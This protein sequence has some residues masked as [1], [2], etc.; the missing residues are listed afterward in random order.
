MAESETGDPGAGRIYFVQNCAA[1][2]T[3]DLDGIGKRYNV[4]ALRGQLL[5]PRQLGAIRSFTLDA[6]TDSKTASAG[7]V[8]ISCEYFQAGDVLNLMAYLRSKD[9]RAASARARRKR[10]TFMIPSRR[11]LL[12][13]LAA[14]AVVRPQRPAAVRR[15]RRSVR[16]RD[17]QLPRSAAGR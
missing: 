13:A 14:V 4:A 12:K 10:K 2:H 17:V 7:N 8:T 11:D 3:S 1:C 16:R 6:L 9:N 5:R 15:Q